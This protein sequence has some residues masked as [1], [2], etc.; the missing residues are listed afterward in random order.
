MV[1][2]L[3]PR[4]PLTQRTPAQTVLSLVASVVLPLLRPLTKAPRSAKLTGRSLSKGL[5]KDVLAQFLSAPYVPLQKN[6][7]ASLL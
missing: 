7:L 1:P 2:G 6:A 5:Y 4:G 3:S